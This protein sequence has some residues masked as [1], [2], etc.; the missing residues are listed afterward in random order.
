[1][2]KNN[3]L[4]ENKKLLIIL[5]VI[6]LG[7]FLYFIYQNYK[8]NQ[9]LD[10]SG[11]SI[12]VDPEVIDTLRVN[13]SVR[14]YVALVDAE[15]DYNAEKILIDQQINELYNNVIPFL[16]E[17]E[18]KLIYTFSNYPHFSGEMTRKGFE[19]LKNN[20]YIKSIEI[21]SFVQNAQSTVQEGI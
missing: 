11:L 17:S 1:M 5:G 16:D 15:I 14:V 4:K 12:E 21:V 7:V 9:I 3:W 20:S 6:I 8:L 19:K 13:D 10:I 18:F 2:K